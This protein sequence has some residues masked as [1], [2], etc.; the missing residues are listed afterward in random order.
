MGGIPTRGATPNHTLVGFLGTGGAD[1]VPPSKVYLVKIYLNPYT[2][3]EAKEFR[4][5]ILQ[6]LDGFEA[7]N[8]AV[9]SLWLN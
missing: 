8:Q 9:P 5:K 4:Q 1:G 3:I 2:S 6:Q 7:R